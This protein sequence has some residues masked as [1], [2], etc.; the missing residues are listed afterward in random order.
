MTRFLKLFCLLSVLTL[1]AAPVLA[2]DSAQTPDD[3]DRI[4]EPRDV[5][6][7]DADTTATPPS[8]DTA[9]PQGHENEQ[10]QTEEEF[11]AD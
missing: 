8:N 9:A 5:Y 2:Q 6:G 4:V 7:D 1:T 11:E 3:E 10:N